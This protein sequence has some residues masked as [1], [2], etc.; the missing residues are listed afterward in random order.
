MITSGDLKVARN[1]GEN[2]GLNRLD[3]RPIDSK[4]NLVLTLA[5]CG[6]RMAPNAGVIVDQ[7]SVIHRLMGESAGLA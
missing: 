6:A 2:T 4:W 7:E 3:P 5:R 1:V